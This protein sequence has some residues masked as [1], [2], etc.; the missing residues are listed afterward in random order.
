MAQ[1]WRRVLYLHSPFGLV[2][3]VSAE[4]NKR[5]QTVAGPP[6]SPTRSFEGLGSQTDRERVLF[7]GTPFSNLCSLVHPLAIGRAVVCL[8]FVIACKYA[9]GH[10]EVSQHLNLL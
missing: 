6:L 1:H 7:I 9:L 3:R 10:S 2:A 8:V 4:I 5:D